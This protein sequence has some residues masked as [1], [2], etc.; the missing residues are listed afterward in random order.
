MWFA[1]FLRC[2]AWP[3]DI[4]LNRTPPPPYPVLVIGRGPAQARMS[5]QGD[6]PSSLGRSTGGSGGSAGGGMVL[7]A[8]AVSAGGGVAPP[9]TAP[10]AGRDVLGFAADHPAYSGHPRPESATAS[11]SGL[12]LAESGSA[13]GG[14][15]GGTGSV[16][17]SSSIGPAP[18]P[19]GCVSPG[20][21]AGA[22]A[23]AAAGAAELGAAAAG[24][25]PAGGAGAGGGGAAGGSAG[26]AA[27]EGNVKGCWR[28]GSAGCVFRVFF[29]F[30]RGGT[31]NW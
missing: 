19:A 8:S 12:R 2:P 25:G 13:I 22:A 1:S 26:A 15:N 30:L 14:R 5:Q 17:V 7:S 24:V 31:P 27:A 29:F 23:T 6:R 18:S 4:P 20:T 21:D 11:P 16:S 28:W 3:P 9:L 10:A